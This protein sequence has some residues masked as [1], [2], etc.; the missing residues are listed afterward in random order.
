MKKLKCHCRE[1]EAEINAPDNLEKEL[2]DNSVTIISLPIR[3]TYDSPFTLPMNRRNEAMFKV[4][5][6]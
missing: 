6:N 2:K 1:V 3:A 4:E 5:I